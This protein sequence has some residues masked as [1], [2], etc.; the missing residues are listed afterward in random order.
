MYNYI[1]AYGYIL[2]SS[3]KHDLARSSFQFWPTISDEGDKISKFCHL[4]SRLWGSWLKNDIARSCFMSYTPSFGNFR[5][6]LTFFNLLVKRWRPLL[7]T[8]NFRG[9]NEK[10]ILFWNIWKFRK[11]WRVLENLWVIISKVGGKLWCQNGH[12]DQSYTCLINFNP[13]YIFTKHIYV[14]SGLDSQL[15]DEKFR[16]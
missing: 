10:K 11:L 3:I 2:I 16:V 12:I 6:V 5:E 15:S 8:R 4:W 1:I 7:A 13:R 9:K 14:F